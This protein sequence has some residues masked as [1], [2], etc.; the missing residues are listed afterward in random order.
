MTAIVRFR[1]RTVYQ[2]R[3]VAFPLAYELIR[4]LPNNS[5]GGCRE[6]RGLELDVVVLVCAR[7]SSGC[8][9]DR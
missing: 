6:S 8:E 5:Y 7:R 9:I 2:R 3:P 4:H 1:S